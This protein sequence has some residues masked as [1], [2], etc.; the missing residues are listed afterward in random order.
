MQVA[1]SIFYTLVHGP[2]RG[3]RERTDNTMIAVG[4]LPWR[5]IPVRRRL[6]LTRR[7]VRVLAFA[8]LSS[9]RLYPGSLYSI[10]CQSPKD[11]VRPSVNAC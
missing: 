1:V 7:N 9:K 11:S 4:H 3:L 8:L 10:I 5:K 2:G 6:W